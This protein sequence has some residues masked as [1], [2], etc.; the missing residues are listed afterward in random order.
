MKMYL[1]QVREFIKKFDKFTLVH[2]LRSRKAQVYSLEKLASSAETSAARDI[3]WKVLPN[4]NINFMV[5]TIDRS[6]TWME[7]YIKYLQNKALSLDE[8]QAQTVQKRAEWFEL[9]E[10]TLYKKSY[11]HPLLK[12]V[13]PEE[14]N[15]ILR[16]IHEGVCGIHQGVRT[17]ISKVLRSGY[18]WPSLRSDAEALIKRCPQCQYH[19]K[20]ERK[21]SNYLSTI[22]AILPFDKWIIDLLGPYPPAK[23]Q[24]NFIIVAIDY[25]TKYVEAEALSSITDKQVCQ[26]MWRNI[27]TRYG[28]PRV[29]IT[30]N[31]RQFVSKNTIGYCDRF[32]L[33]IRFS[34]VSRPQTN[35]KVESANKEILNGIKK[36]IDWA[37]GTWD[38]ELPDILWS[39]RT[40]VKE[41]MGHTPFS[42]VYGSEAVLPVE[43]GIP[44]NRIAY[45]W[46]NE[47][48]Q[49]KKPRFLLFFG[50]FLLRFR[51]PAIVIAANVLL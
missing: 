11:T 49:W 7:P 14:G 20:I 35:G 3:I 40:T 42:L 6:E 19:S 8:G 15:Y 17:V 48:H 43:I 45:Y 1:Q 24:R 36:K 44:T 21:P 41:A 12:C 22:Q 32:N 10:R 4:P 27:I 2:I 34:S 51:P 30:D 9:H 46:H 26:F 28:I 39:S 5:D 31:G 25:F 18:Y 33:Q 47:N 29:N 16:E 38:E 13:S 23:G 37:K 50:H